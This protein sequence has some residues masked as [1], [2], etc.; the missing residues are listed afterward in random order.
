[1]TDYSRPKKNPPPPEKLP[2]T[3]AMKKLM[4]KAKRG[5]TPKKVR[6]LTPLQ[7]I[8]VEKKKKELLVKDVFATTFSDLQHTQKF[9]LKTWAMTN[10]TEFYKLAS[11]LLPIQVTG[12]GGG[13]IELK[14]VTFE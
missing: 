9:S 12:E 6:E 13:P 11:K 2:D 10:P 14:N 8:K 4:L 7:I 5:R 3:K 1:M